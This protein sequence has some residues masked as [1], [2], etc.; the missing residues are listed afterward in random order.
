MA[1]AFSLATNSASL[2]MSSASTFELSSFFRVIAI[3]PLPVPKSIISIFWFLNN[4]FDFLIVFST[5]NSVS[6]LGI[7]TD[8]FTL[9]IFP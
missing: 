5:N 7:N 8:S 9:I 4:W 2:E 6:N 1:L 3:H